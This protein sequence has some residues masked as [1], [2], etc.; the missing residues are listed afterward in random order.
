MTSQYLRAFT[1]KLLKE[2]GLDLTL[3]G[4][5]RWGAAD[6]PMV[7]PYLPRSLPPAERLVFFLGIERTFF[8]LKS[9]TLILIDEEGPTL[10]LLTSAN[11][12][13]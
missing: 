3:S 11:D 1:E 5:Y 8:G 9:S 6:A 10:V 12:E 7:R 4:P 2:R 13:G